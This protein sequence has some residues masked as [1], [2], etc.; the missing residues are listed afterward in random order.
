MSP[1]LPPMDGYE[2][3]F[4]AY[5]DSKQI[6]SNPDHHGDDIYD[7]RSLSDS[8]AMSYKEFGRTY[9]SYRAGSYHYPNDPSEAERLDEQY[10]ILK[11]MMEGRLHFAPFSSANPPSKVLDIATGTGTWAVEF[12]DEYPEAE[13]IGTDLSPIQPAFVPPNVRFFIE[14]SAEEWDY[15][16]DFDYIHTRITLGCWTDMKTQIMQRAFDHLRPGGWLECQ[17]VMV[18]PYCDDGTM[19]SDFGWLRWSQELAMASEMAGRQLKMGDNIKKWM[20]AVGFVNVRE[21]VIKIPIGG[22]AK[23]RRLRHVGM[24]WQWNLMSGLSGFTLGLFNRVL[25]RTVEDIQVRGSE[26][27]SLFILRRVEVTNMC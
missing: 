19:P 21:A 13:V 1:P 17:E 10:E 4:E 7:S 25:G 9:H 6:D 15:P 22:W 12:G 20:E 3:G 11:E 2:F 27:R 5:L 26:I 16:A 18:E 8:I 23:D 14:D 24:L